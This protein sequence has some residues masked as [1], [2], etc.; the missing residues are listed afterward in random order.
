MN[1]NKKEITLSVQ[2]EVEASAT[3][4]Q[5]AEQVAKALGTD[6][7]RG[8]KDAGMR[9]IGKLKI[10]SSPKEK[11]EASAHGYDSRMWEKVTC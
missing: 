2:L 1:S 4:E 6:Q 11:I 10:T 3:E 8:L 7:S 9:S 5:I